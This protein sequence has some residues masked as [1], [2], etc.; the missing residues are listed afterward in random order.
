MINKTKKKKKKKLSPY[1]P[2]YAEH[3]YVSLHV[4][5]TPAVIHAV[6]FRGNFEGLYHCIQ[7]GGVGFRVGVVEVCGPADSQ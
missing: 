1:I 4:V 6:Q 5:P 7:V 3:P 2:P